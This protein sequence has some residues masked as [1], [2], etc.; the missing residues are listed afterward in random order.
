MLK[1]RSEKRERREEVAVSGGREGRREERRKG[2]R[3]RGRKEK[4]VSQECVCE[5]F[6]GVW[7][8]QGGVRGLGAG[9]WIG[10]RRG[11]V[12]RGRSAGYEYVRVG[13]R[14]TNMSEGTD[15]LIMRGN[16]VRFAKRRREEELTKGKRK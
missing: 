11:C 9:Y 2:Q 5:V 6:T 3:R 15:W 8:C 1:K 14:D 10:E 12:G 13:M 4:S 7:G 16:S